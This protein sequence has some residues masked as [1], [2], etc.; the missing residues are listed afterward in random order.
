MKKYSLAINGNP[1]TV[2]IIEVTADIV[3][4]EVNGAEH[5]VAIEDIENINMFPTETIERKPVPTSTQPTAAKPASN[6]DFCSFGS[7]NLNA[8]IP[9]QIILIDVK[10]GD[11]IK[12]GDR[13]LIL[14][15]MKME[16]VL[17]SIRDG[18]IKEVLVAEG[19]AVTQ[20]Q[21]LIIFE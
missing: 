11:S 15:A 16:N 3:K 9:G 4:A 14:E 20:D 21:P 7:G 6:G 12:K 18:V 10:Q 19:E 17:T 8:P 5:T 2:R 1:Y 13:L